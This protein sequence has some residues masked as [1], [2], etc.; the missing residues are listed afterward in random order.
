MLNHVRHIFFI[1]RIGLILSCF[2]SCNLTAYPID[3]VY[4]W[5]D[6]SDPEW[7]KI[8]NSY[9]EI[10]QSEKLVL[11]DSSC[12]SR[13]TDHQELR[14]SLRSLNKYAPFI[15]HIYIVT[16][17]QKPSWIRPHPKITFIDHK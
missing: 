6:G 17:G 5:V 8:K 11:A 4:T 16:M 1:K 13:F 9:L 3:A 14:Y 15:N 12:V 10:T 2:F 7:A